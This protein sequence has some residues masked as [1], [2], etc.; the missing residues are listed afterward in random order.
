MGKRSR[1]Y[2]RGGATLIKFSSRVPL[3]NHDAN[4]V[5]SRIYMSVPS[6]KSRSFTC[7]LPDVRR[8]HFCL[9]LLGDDHQDGGYGDLRQRNLSRGFLEQTGLLYSSGWVSKSIQNIL[10]FFKSELSPSKKKKLLQQ[11]INYL[12]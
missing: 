3:I 12:C 7:Y 11:I 8:Y 4:Y 10:D 6:I 5:R 1:N 2:R 9:L